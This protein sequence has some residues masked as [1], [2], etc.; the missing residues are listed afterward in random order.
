MIAT[1]CPRNRLMQK[2]KAET[3]FRRKNGTKNERKGRNE[4]FER[5]EAYLGTLS[6]GPWDLSL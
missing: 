2:L 3:C 5:E 6:P 1:P 4:S